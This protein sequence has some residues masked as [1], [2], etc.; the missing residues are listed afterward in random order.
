MKI[1]RG[2]RRVLFFL[3]ALSLGRPAWALREL[4]YHP[5]LI[6][7]I[8]EVFLDRD[9]L[10]PPKLA[11]YR[12]TIQTRRDEV[13][14]AIYRANRGFLGRNAKEAEKKAREDDTVVNF[15]LIL[16]DLDRLASIDPA[17]RAAI[18]RGAVRALEI[19]HSLRVEG[20]ILGSVQQIRY[21]RASYKNWSIPLKSPITNEATNL[22]DPSTGKFL[23]HDELAALAA[24]GADLSRLEPDPNSTFWHRHD[25]A[26]V[27]VK[28]YFQGGQA[29]LQRGLRVDFP[30]QNQGYFKA[31]RKTQS[32]PKLDVTFTT[33]DGRKVKIKLKVAREIH[34]EPTAASLAAALGFHSDVS[35]HVESF[36]MIL[37][38]LTYK[39]FKKE[40]NS[41]YSS[42]DLDKYVQFVGSD[43]DGNYVVF[44]RGLLE[45][46]P[47]GLNRVGPWAW[48]ELGHRGVRETRALILFDQWIANAD[49]KE[50]ENNK[51]IIREVD[52]TATMFH[53]QHDLGF[54]FGKLF[55]ETPGQFPWNLVDR[56]DSQRIHLNY[57]A[58]QKNSGFEHITINDARWTYRLIGRLTRRQITDAVELGAWPEGMKKLLVEKLIHRRNEMVQALGLQE[59]IGILPVDRQVSSEDGLVKNGELKVP[60]VPK[61]PEKFE[62]GIWETISPTVAKIRDALMR[63]GAKAFSGMS[64]FDLAPIEVGLDS[65]LISNVHF[66]LSREV[67]ENPE[68]E[69]ENDRY[70]VR[71]TFRIGLELGAGFVVGGRVA[72]IRSYT[73][74]YPKPTSTAAQYAGNFIYNVLLPY[75]AALDQLPPR[76]ILIIEDSLEGGGVLRLDPDLLNLALSVPIGIKGMA[77]KVYLQRSIVSK[78]GDRVRLYEDKSLYTELVARLYLRLAMLKLPLGQHTASIGSI[79]RTWYEIPSISSLNDLASR[80]ILD[81]AVAKGDFT[82]VEKIGRPAEVSSKF[83]QSVLR[84]SLLGFLT[85]DSRFRVDELRIVNPQ[86]T[87]QQLQALRELQVQSSARSGWSWLDNGETRSRRFTLSSAMDGDTREIANPEIRMSFEISDKNTTTSEYSEKYLRFIDQL[88]SVPNWMLFTPELH[89]RNHRWGYLH[90]TSNVVY[91]AAAIEALL[92]LNESAFFDAFERTFAR[93]NPRT[94]EYFLGFAQFL[95]GSIESARKATTDSE[96]LVRLVRGLKYAV[97]SEEGTLNGILLGIV[98]RLVGYDK[99]YMN[100]MV[101]LPSDRENKLPGG[102]P[103]FREMGERPSKE[104]TPFVFGQV[105][106]SEFWQSL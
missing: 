1:C 102:V 30:E 69:D 4:P 7:K 43:E 46:K 58:F 65:S 57:E 14:Q 12:K 68:P 38:K 79:N 50:S 25:I 96:R 35:K 104:Q 74:I 92:N 11:A 45:S 88:A 73:L 20:E 18:L 32:K 106:P 27:D 51:L 26:A 55:R 78:R 97:F 28:P 61:F 56:I 47:E 40:W 87:E 81:T 85:S 72:F 41:Y 76:H 31:V 94:R 105:Q 53:A 42:Y 8:E 36:K 75:S 100:A 34:S 48:G 39:Q 6:Q 70:L 24:A 60:V 91:G 77:S 2:R 49:L 22:L 71:D 29:P 13:H 80:Q 52:G 82:G 59:E 44:H 99:I 66:N 98:N 64:S 10:S 86:A 84:L 103:L 89:S 62:Q 15:D 21:I 101:A 63:L 93:S 9:V 17:D 54:A 33:S 37:G 16:A 23:S 19:D 3:V 67:D 90:T 83:R 5:Q 95:Y